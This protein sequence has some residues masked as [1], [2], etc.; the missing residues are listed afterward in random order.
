MTASIRILTTSSLDSSPSL[1]LVSPNGSKTLINCGEG[2]QRSFLESSSTPAGVGSLRVSSVNRICLTHINH[3]ALGGLPGMIL[4]TADVAEAAAV[5]FKL[6][7]N[8]ERGDQKRKA[9]M[10]SNDG[11]PDLEIVGPVGT[12][13]FLHSLRHFMRRD[14]FNVHTYEGQFD[15][16]TRKKSSQNGG[17]ANKR[18]KMKMQKNNEETSFSIES[19]QITYTVSN[20]EPS[21]S[22]QNTKHVASYVFTT[23]PIPGKF[24]IEKARELNVP[25]G[26]LCGQLKAGKTVTFIDPK[27]NEERT[28]ESTDVVAKASPGVGVAVIYCPNKQVL[29]E[30]KISSTIRAFQKNS[31]NDA[32][33]V[34]LDVIVHLTPKTIFES[35][36]YQSWCAEF[37]SG[38]DHITLHVAENIEERA[39]SNN[40][41]PFVSAMRGSARR[42][43][44][45]DELFPMP[46][47]PMPM[48]DYIK[49]IHPLTFTKGCPMMEYLLMPRSKRGLNTSTIKSLYSPTEMDDLVT[50]VTLT[51]ALQ[52]A[53]K[54]LLRQDANMSVDKNGNESN[55]NLGELIFTG[56]G[57]AV[58]C[59]HRNVTGMY[60]RMKNGNS[61]LLVAW[62][63]TFARAQTSL[64]LMGLL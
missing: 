33:S 45:H 29:E 56:T 55:C 3:D 24:L 40:S 25:M 15:S 43:F 12:K 19:I 61:M 53:K 58:P 10:I 47:I 11:M 7:N 38:V 18:T 60:L 1:L 63:Q 37:K 48:S 32:S 30:L 13:A 17:S 6:Q 51:G 27:T 8:L 59:K 44:I 62:W 5:E 4:T 20:T 64:L 34:Q 22:H 23:P 26:P 41:S 42:S 54:I 21:K 49:D 39:A 2:C 50:E 31:D 9:S 46:E 52:L 36:A 14:R 16:S 57:S 35:N 28:V